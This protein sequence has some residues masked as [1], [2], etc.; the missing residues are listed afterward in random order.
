MLFNSYVFIAAFLPVTWLLF[1]AIGRRHHG[2]ALGWLVGASLLYYGWWYPPYLV[3]LLTSMVG[4]FA[5]GRLLAPREGQTRPRAL[6]V[7]GVA[8][9]LALL[10]W[11]KYAAFL[12]ANLLAL[13]GPDLALPPIV[14]P[15]AISFFTFQQIAY[16]VDTYRG[17]TREANPLHYALFVSFFPQLIA[18]PIVHHSEMMP[19][20]AER[21]VTR[22]DL[23]ALALALPWFTLGLF[24]KV[25]VADRL[26]EIATPI[27]AHAET[28]GA[29][30]WAEGW[31]GA[32]A[33]TYQLYF[34]FSGY[35]DMAIGLG[36]MFGVT[37]PLNFN[38]PYQARNIADFWRR[39]H[40]TLSRFLRDYLY[41]AL[42]G[43]RH[44][45]GRR[46]VNLMATMVLGGL[47]HGAGWTFVAWGT[48]HGVYLVIH[49][50]FRTL[51]PTVRHTPLRTLASSGLT[52]LAAVVGWVFFRAETFAGGFAMLRAMAGL[53]ETPLPSALQGWLG[54]G[55][56]VGLFRHQLFDNVPLS[57]AWV[58]A[59]ALACAL[60]PNT[61]QLFAR[62][63]PTPAALAWVDRLRGMKIR[64][65][66]WVMAG[67]GALA[68]VC[69]LHLTQVSEFLYFQF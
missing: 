30:T 21:R 68:T 16:L 37:L 43:N 56:P 6:L 13:G 1:Y 24:K 5:Y 51:L 26:A 69:L 49:R 52:L 55:A 57:M 45:A 32:L 53:D 41:I 58:L 25:V 31:A 63:R 42:G 19:Q 20:F 62:A 2:A 60:L 54:Q 23:G 36:L 46:Y 11:Y 40:M 61:Q 67:L 44:G 34:D 59:A 9:N 65:S 38:S 48:L 50:L 12:A 3:L 14:L 7:A 64:P 29:L 17:L 28:G 47:W 18:G 35:S 33:Y 39:W 66:P 22:V 10:G 27:F 4:N 15:L 8:V